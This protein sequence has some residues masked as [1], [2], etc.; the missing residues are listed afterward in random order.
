MQGNLFF[1]AK[2]R[3]LFW[4]AEREG[5]TGPDDTNPP[6]GR[7]HHEKELCKGRA[8]ALQRKRLYS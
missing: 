5:S 3:I 8:R 4:G 2:M 6:L 7:E 1:F